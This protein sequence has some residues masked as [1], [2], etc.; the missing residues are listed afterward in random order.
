MCPYV[1]VDDLTPLV[2][3]TSLREVQLERAAIM[4]SEIAEFLKAHQPRFKLTHEGEVKPWGVVYVQLARWM[5][6]DRI[7]YSQLAKLQVGSINLE[8][9]EVSPARLDRLAIVSEEIRH[10]TFG[11]VG[12]VDGLWDFVLSCPNLETLNL[13]VYLTCGRRAFL[14]VVVQET[15]VPRYSAGTAHPGFR[16]TSG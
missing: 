4:Q 7:N 12:Q 1:L 16:Q 13:G 8:R 15:E 11:D 2:D 9:L 5:A 10:L 14:S 6:E 3:S